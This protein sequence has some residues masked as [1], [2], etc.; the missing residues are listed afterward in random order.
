MILLSSVSCTT[1]KKSMEFVDSDLDGVHDLRDACPYEAGSFFNLGCPNDSQLVTLTPANQTKSTD[2][3]LD[4][5]MDEKDECPLVYG[6]PF[7]QGCP[8]AEK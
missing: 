4:G 3:D 7:N 5:I 2:S 8:I 1:Q 6:S